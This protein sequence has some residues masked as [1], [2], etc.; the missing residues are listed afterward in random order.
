MIDFQLDRRG[1]D[2]APG[3][4]RCHRYSARVGPRQGGKAHAN[5]EM[6]RVAC[7]DARRD[8]DAADGLTQLE[9]RTKRPIQIRIIRLRR[10]LASSVVLLPTLRQA[11]MRG[12]SLF[13]QPS[14]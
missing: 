10:M 7:L 4:Q 9:A 8:D 5:L 14:R 3:H 2:S 12:P 1:F 6:D 11:S 13:R